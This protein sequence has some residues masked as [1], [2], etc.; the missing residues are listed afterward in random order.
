MA[1]AAVVTLQRLYKDSPTDRSGDVPPAIKQ[2]NGFADAVMHRASKAEGVPSYL[3]TDSAAWLIDAVGKDVELTEGVTFRVV[4]IDRKGTSDIG[5]VVIELRSDSLSANRLRDFANAVHDEYLAHVSQQ[6]TRSPCVF[7]HKERPSMDFRGVPFEDKAQ[8]R[9]YEIA[10]APTH[11]AFAKCPFQSNKT[12]DNLCGADARLVH[13][14]VRFFLE[15]RAWYD[16]KGVPYRLGILLS[17]ACGS[18]KSSCIKAIANLTRRHVVNVNFA[19]VRT[20]SQLRRLFQSDDLHV[21]EDDDKSDV[22]KLHVPLGQRL[23]VMEEIDAI[24]CDVLNDRAS[25]GRGGPAEQTAGGDEL[26]LADILQVLDGMMESP[27]RII[28]ITSNFP[29]RLD[30]AL[31]R[32]G[33]IDLNVRFRDADAN[34][35]VELYKKL[36][37]RTFPRKKLQSKLPDGKLSIAEATEVVFRT[38]GRRGN[39]ASAAHSVEHVVSELCAYA[40][41]KHDAV[42]EAEA[43]ILAALE[44]VSPPTTACPPKIA[45]DALF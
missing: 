7:Q 28:V 12:F 30:R 5:N 35:L 4:S 6:L 26:T 11:I 17:G 21:Y 22:V 24:G 32:P 37:D 9:R 39:A 31:V 13:E 44:D 34:T 43:G 38:L 36:T 20:G 18:G 10:N 41:A 33:R 8:R 2:M 42:A 16:A 40:A 1:A 19:N 15:N 23:Y 27:G 14:R 3:M 29:E 45:E 25:S